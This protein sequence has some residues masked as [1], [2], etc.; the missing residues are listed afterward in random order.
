MTQDEADFQKGKAIKCLTRRLDA[1]ILCVENGR[2]ATSPT[3]GEGLGGPL[4]EN[5]VVGEGPTQHAPMPLV[6]PFSIDF[7]KRTRKEMSEKGDS[8]IGIN[9]DWH[10]FNYLHLLATNIKLKVSSLIKPERNE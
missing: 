6:Q 4:V 7:C 9:S 1:G 10:C 2:K 3:D 8:N 5:N